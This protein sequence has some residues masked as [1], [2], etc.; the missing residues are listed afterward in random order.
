MPHRVN[1]EPRPGFGHWWAVALG[2]VFV[3]LGLVLAGGGAWLAWLGGSWYYLL[4]G[5]G[6][7]LSGGLTMTGRASGALVY[8]VVWVLTLLW[9][10]WEVG[11]DAGPSSP[12]SSPRPSCSS[13]SSPRSWRSAGRW[14]PLPSPPSS[15][16][17]SSSRATAGRRR[18]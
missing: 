4:A 7:V 17:S 10:F 6:L 1:R 3:A 11:L 8:A 5:L 16:S 14:S 15:A 13:S 18:C 9:A 2:V 12:A